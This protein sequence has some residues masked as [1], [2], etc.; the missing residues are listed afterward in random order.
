LKS[1]EIPGV[2][3]EPPN[4]LAIVMVHGE[5]IAKAVATSSRYAK[6]K[7]SSRALETLESMTRSDFRAKYDCDCQGGE[8]IAEAGDIGTAI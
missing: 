5:A 6:I 4:I 2:D 7:A 3:G 8:E 1:G